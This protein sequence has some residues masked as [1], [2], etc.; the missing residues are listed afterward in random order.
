MKTKYLILTLLLNRTPKMKLALPWQNFIFSFFFQ[1]IVCICQ[2]NKHLSNWPSIYK[3]T[4]LSCIFD[5][6]KLVF[7]TQSYIFEVVKR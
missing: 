2:E 5:V 4:P 3:G 6:S 7:Y 1:S